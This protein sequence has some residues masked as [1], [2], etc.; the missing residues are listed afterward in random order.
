MLPLRGFQLVSDLLNFGGGVSAQVDFAT[1]TQNFSRAAVIGMDFVS[2][3]ETAALFTFLDRFDIAGRPYKQGDSVPLGLFTPGAYPTTAGA[4]LGRLNRYFPGSRIPLAN[5]TLC[6]GMMING[7]EDIRL[8]VT[9][10]FA[11]V[12]SIQNIILHCVEFPVKAYPRAVQ[13][14][15][16]ELWDRLRSG[17]GQFHFVGNRYDVAGGGHAR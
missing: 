7:R 3:D 2:A 9:K 12:P 17:I 10:R 14:R 15:I 8:A 13:L 11:A 6:S 5:G 16:D 4:Q 1:K